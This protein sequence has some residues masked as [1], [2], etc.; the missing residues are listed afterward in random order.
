MSPVLSTKSSVV[1]G[2]PLDRLHLRLGLM[3]L[4]APLIVRRSVIC[5]P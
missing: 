4:H 1:Q 3:K 2:G 5:S